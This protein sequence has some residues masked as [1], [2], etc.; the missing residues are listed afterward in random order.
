MALQSTVTESSFHRMDALRR[1]LPVGEQ[2]SM[3]KVLGLIKSLVEGGKSKWVRKH[4]FYKI[5]QRPGESARQLYGRAVEAAAEC[6]FGHNYCH[7]PVPIAQS[8]I[9]SSQ[10]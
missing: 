8:G 6:D 3:D 5:G 2:T 10:S 9:S 4:E 1:Q 7:T